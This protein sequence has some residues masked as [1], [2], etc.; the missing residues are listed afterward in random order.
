MSHHAVLVDHRW[1]LL[2]LFVFGTFTYWRTILVAFKFWQLIKGLYKHLCAG[3]CV[4]I[5]FQIICVNTKTCGCWVIPT[6]STP[7]PSP[8]KHKASLII[9]ILPCGTFVI[10]Q[11]PTINQHWH[12]IIKQSPYFTFGFTVV[13]LWVLTNVWCTHQ[14]SIIHSNFIALKSCAP[15]TDPSLHT[16]LT[17]MDFFVST[18]L[19]SPECYSWNHILWTFSNCLLSLRNKHLRFNHVFWGLDSTFLFWNWVI[20]NSFGLIPRYVVAESYA[21]TVFV[22]KT[23]QNKTT[24]KFSSK[25]AVPIW[26]MQTM[27]ENSCCSTSSPTF[28]IVNILDFS[29]SRKYVRVISRCFFKFAIPYND[30]HLSHSYLPSVPTDVYSDI[31]SIF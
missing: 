6:Y 22:L 27:N 29:H 25:V 24:V 2:L 5:S 15:P 7:T 11:S 13:H 26:F 19:P 1:W 18:I 9:N 28:G 8:P 3:F 4:D 20:F 14:Y 30:E 31:L 10:K 23:K 16:N 17:T 21:K 12:I